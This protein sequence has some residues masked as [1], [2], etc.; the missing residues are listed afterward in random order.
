MILIAGIQP[1]TT[2]ADPSPRRCPAC[3]LHQAH[4]KRVDHYLSLFFVP[5]IRVKK[6]EERLVCDRCAGPVE[7]ETAR[8]GVFASESRAPAVCRQCGGPLEKGFSYCPHCGQR[9]Q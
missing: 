3:G 7:P 2:V 8:A 4:L 1:K 9:Q 6:G 5:V